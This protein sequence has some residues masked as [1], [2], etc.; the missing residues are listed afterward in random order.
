M[1]TATFATVILPFST[2]VMKI[3]MLCC[4]HSRPSLPLILTV[5]VDV[6][7][8]ATSPEIQDDRGETRA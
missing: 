1:M 7:A 4:F 8:V 5:V 2:A 3:M 6:D